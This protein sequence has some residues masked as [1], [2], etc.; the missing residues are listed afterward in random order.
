MC[1][2]TPGARGG[3]VGAVVLAAGGSSRMGRPKQLLRMGSISLV[4]RAV[5]TVTQ[6]LCS[7][8]VAVIGAH[9]ADVRQ[10][11]EDL[12]VQI[13]ENADWQEGMGGS[14]RAGVRALMDAR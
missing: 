6:T 3:P 7:P 5:L 13:T 1:G 8:V 2:V 10:E 14:I 9:G 11:I 4:R 12:P